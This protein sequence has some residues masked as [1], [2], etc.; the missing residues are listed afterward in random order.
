MI[1]K[2][3]QR[4][5]DAM[6]KLRVNMTSDDGSFTLPVLSSVRTTA[7]GEKKE[8]QYVHLGFIS[9]QPHPVKLC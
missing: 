7:W 8:N 9:H 3:L 5:D 6:L 2:E 4:V 1:L